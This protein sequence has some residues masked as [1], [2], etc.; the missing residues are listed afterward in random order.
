MEKFKT[1]PFGFSLSFER[2]PRG[3]TSEQNKQLTLTNI[4]LDERTP[5]PGSHDLKSSAGA[6]NLSE[7]Q[8]RAPKYSDIKAFLSSATSHIVLWNLQTVIARK[9]NI[10]CPVNK[11]GKSHMA[12][13]D[14]S[15]AKQLRMYLNTCPSVCLTWHWKPRQATDNMTAIRGETVSREKS[16]VC[17]VSFSHE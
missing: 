17:S 12:F 13:S 8:A 4:F 10:C 6:L 3:L 7:Q 2:S 9:A 16:M 5:T 14:C 11:F 1:E 15:L